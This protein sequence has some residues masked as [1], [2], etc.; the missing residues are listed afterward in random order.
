MC[1]VEELNWL[2]C[3][4]KTIIYIALFITSHLPLQATPGSLVTVA[5]LMPITQA[6][7]WA[8]PWIPCLGKEEGNCLLAWLLGG[9]LMARWVHAPLAPTWVPTW[10]PTWVPVWALIWATYHLKWELGCAHLQASTESRRR[11]Q[12]CSTDLPTQYT[13][14]TQELKYNWSFTIS[15]TSTRCV[16]VHRNHDSVR[17]SVL[18]PRFDTSS[19][20]QKNKNKSPMQGLF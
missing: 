20:Q 10:A 17:T 19:V 14:G 3:H 4:C 8:D 11:P 9:C 18:R 16:M 15:L 13:T 5:C 2:Y 7:A 1:C 12:Q 6:L